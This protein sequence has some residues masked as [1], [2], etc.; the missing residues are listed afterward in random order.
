MFSLISCQVFFPRVL[1]FSGWH[2]VGRE[3]LDFGAKYFFEGSWVPGLVPGWAWAISMC[4]IGFWCKVLFSKVPGLVPSWA[5]P[6]LC[7]LLDFGAEYFFPRFLGSQVGSRP[8]V[9]INFFLFY[10]ILVQCIFPDRFQIPRF[11]A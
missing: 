5:W 1:G 6:F 11:Q 4:F 2:P 3:H 7:V 8:G 10:S 9:V